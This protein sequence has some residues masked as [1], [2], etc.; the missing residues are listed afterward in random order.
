[1]L[2]STR[3][4]Q[5]CVGSA[6]A[7]WLHIRARTRMWRSPVAG[8]FTINVGDMLQVYSNDRYVAPLHRVLANRE[9]CRYSAPFFFNPVSPPAP[10]LARAARRP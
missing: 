3:L 4:S 2:C 8:A 6:S 10:P 1:M 7:H 5:A 9:R